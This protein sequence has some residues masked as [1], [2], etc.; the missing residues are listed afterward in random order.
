MARSS[1]VSV[2]IPVYNGGAYIGEAVRSVLCQSYD[3]LQLVICDNCSTDGTEDRV[4]SFRD[5]RIT[6]NRNEANLGLVGNANRCLE[7]ATGEY[8]CILHHDDAMLPENLER[9]VRLLDLHP[10]VGFVHS[11][12]VVVD[13]SGNVRAN[14][15][16]DVDSRRDYVEDGFTVFR[17]FVKKMPWGASIFIGAVVARRSCYERVG[18]FSP[19][20]AYC[21]DSEMFMRLMLFYDVACIGTP[22]VK[23]RVHE[24]STSSN[25]GNYCAAP[26]L[27][28]HYRAVKS[29]FDAYR[30]RIPGAGRLWSEVSLTFGRRALQLCRYWEQQDSACA[31]GLLKEAVRMAP[32]IVT[33]A[34][35]WKLA[36]RMVIG[37]KWLE[38]LRGMRDA[39]RRRGNG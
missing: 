23:Y 30:K 32:S 36:L 22:L 6:Y 10:Q 20:L 8:V 16:W 24:Q 39:G 25:W 34:L 19:R 26:Y 1:R 4:R 5:D 2:C 7:L 11:D 12:I 38:L 18:G 21:N 17:R 35:F 29:V 14:H 33:E 37:T 3:N 13:S 27:K 28:E 9:K 31:V 15:I